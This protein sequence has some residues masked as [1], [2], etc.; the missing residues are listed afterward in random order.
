MAAA[1]LVQLRSGPTPWTQTLLTLLAGAWAIY[2]ARTV[3]VAAAIVAPCAAIALGH[4]VPS[5]PA[6]DRRGRTAL[7]LAGV[8]ASLVLAGLASGKPA[9]PPR[10]DWANAELEKLAAGTPVLNAWEWGGYLAWR[11]PD[12]NFVVSG[13]GDMYTIDELDRNVAL[14]RTKSG[15]LEDLEGT[16]AEIALLAPDS[17]LAYGLEHTA[18]WTVVKSSDE[19]VLLHAPE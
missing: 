19:M 12:L 5:A 17:E 15:W 13:F 4:L 3:P 8:V 16:G 10:P 14:T 6:L 11:H 1:L 7:L 9:G 2:A 18:G